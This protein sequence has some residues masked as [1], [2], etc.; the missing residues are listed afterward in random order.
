MSYNF[1]LEY[2]PIKSARSSNFLSFYILNN[3]KNPTLSEIM[4]MKIITTLLVFLWMYSNMTNSIYASRLPLSRVQVVDGKHFIRRLHP[5]KSISE[6]IEWKQSNLGRVSVAKPPVVVIV[7]KPSPRKMRK[8][9]I[10][11]NT[12][13]FNN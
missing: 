12:V 5:R 13:K 1:C 2:F 7:Q 3:I 10:S 6:G 9:V 4:Q 11:E 8:I